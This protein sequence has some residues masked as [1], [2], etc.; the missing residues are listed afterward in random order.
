MS[1]QWLAQYRD[2]RWQ[3]KRLQIMERAQFTCECC[4]AT[5]TTLNVHH[6]IYF[7]DRA[8]W[9]YQDSYLSCL[10]EDCHSEE[11]AIRYWLKFYQAQMNRQQLLDLAIHAQ[12]MVDGK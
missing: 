7:K 5:T 1:D 3:R 9:N 2:P 8:P 12:G 11:T 6:R 10:C 4:G